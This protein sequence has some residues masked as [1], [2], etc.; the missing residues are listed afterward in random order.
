D[1]SLTDMKAVCEKGYAVFVTDHF[2]EY[3]LAKKPDVQ[4]GEING[5]GKLSAV[6]AK[7]VLQAVS[8][9]RKLT[10]E[11]QAAADVNG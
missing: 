5:D 7:W 9:S 10:P 1:G 4:K 2:S 8:G 11:Q 6:D 3:V